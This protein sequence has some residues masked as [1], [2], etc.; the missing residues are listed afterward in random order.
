MNPPTTEAAPRAR[1]ASPEG[2]GTL[3]RQRAVT[4]AF[5]GLLVAAVVLARRSAGPTDTNALAPA[6]AMARHGFHLTEV[7]AEAGVSFTHQAPTFD[8]KLAHI[9]PQMA[10]M[11][12]AVA[13]ADFDRDGWAD[14]YATNSG[15]GT[16]NRLYRNRADGT[17]EDVAAALGVADV[18]RPGTGVSTGA[19]WG[20]YDN[21]GFDDLFVDKW[22]R[23]ELFHNDAGRG[24]TRVTE[25]AGLPDWVNATAAVWLD[26]DADGRLDLFLGGYYSEAIDLW[27]LDSTRMMPESFEYA[28]NGGKKHLFRNLG[29]GRFEDVAAEV[30]L[31]SSR[32]AL[33]AAAADLRGTGYPDLVIA[34]D[35]G[36]SEYFANDGGR[37]REVGRETGIGARPKSGMNVGFGDVF[38]QG[39]AAIYITNISEEGILLQGNN[40][41]V[42]REAAAGDVPVYD[43]LAASTGVELG[44]W[45][46]GAQF[47]DLNNDGFQDLFL[48]NG[49]V[50]A[51]PRKSYWYD[52]SKVA[53]GNTAI[54]SDAANWPPME[55]MSLSG[56]QRKRVWVND[57]AG[58]FADVAAQV[59]VDET[60]DG[61]AVAVADFWNRGVQD[62]VVAHQRGPL[63]LYRN[64]VDPANGWIAFELEGTRSNR[65]ALGASVTLTWNGQTQTQHVLSASGFCAQNQRRLHFGMGPGGRP[66]RATVR[67]PSGAEETIGAP[68]PNQVHRVVER[69]GEG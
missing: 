41:W 63:L 58:R 15:E 39:R 68:A 54:I 24:F 3:T 52:Y 67:W 6:E 43:N 21:D 51:D 4:L 11:G 10:A 69:A 44:G 62:V 66:E 27:H 9:M 25:G 50:S 45:S 5:L 30:G 40:L 12:A 55:D 26:Y 34:N 28:Q 59:G 19:L 1:Q 37:F 64:E 38:N 49:F 7:S 18:N 42:P 60:A 33:A 17:F 36:V 57:G 48:T 2:R 16:P 8:A 56:H 20:D 46:F 65:S 53:G 29:D 32:W 22:G 31:V 61:R 14:M 23:P 13:V 47:A 35:Y